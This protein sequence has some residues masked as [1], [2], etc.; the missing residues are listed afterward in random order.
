MDRPRIRLEPWGADGLPLLRA[1][2]G[3]PEMTRFVGGPESEE[4]LAD[5]QALFERLE[6]EGTGRM[7]RI[8]DGTTGEA[9]G[10]VGYWDR[11]GGDEDV[12][13]AGW[14]VLPAYQGRGVAT[15]ATGLAIAHARAEAK[16]RFLHAYPSVENAASN[17][18]CARLGFTLLGAEDF[19]YP[20]GHTLRCNDWRLDLTAPES[21]GP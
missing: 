17:A 15:A 3:D 20:P 13:E 5:R 11:A 21:S 12:Y 1:T 18:L 14:F 7:F 19:E 2:L 9:L 6:A 10:S 4:K 8:V 16:H